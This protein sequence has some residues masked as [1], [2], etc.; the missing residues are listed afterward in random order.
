MLSMSSSLAF[1]FKLKTFQPAAF[2]THVAIIMTITAFCKGGKVE[3]GTNTLET[4]K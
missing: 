1:D 4:L 2:A 3:E